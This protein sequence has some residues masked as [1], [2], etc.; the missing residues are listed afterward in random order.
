[1]TTITNKVPPMLLVAGKADYVV[2]LVNQGW[3]YQG[4]PSGFSVSMSNRGGSTSTTRIAGSSASMGGK[5]QQLEVYSMCFF[6]YWLAGFS[7]AGQRSGRSNK[8]SY[9][10]RPVASSPHEGMPSNSKHRS[11]N[12]SQGLQ[13]PHSPAFSA[14]QSSSSFVC[15]MLSA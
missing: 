11:P 15:C 6:A 14:A 10:S 1:M 12:P 2:R 13:S 5:A 7:R 9:P 8:H 4:R 3:F